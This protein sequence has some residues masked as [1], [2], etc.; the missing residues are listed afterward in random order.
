MHVSG[1][2]TLPDLKCFIFRTE[3]NMSMVKYAK[4]VQKLLL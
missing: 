1:F 4:G 3:Q 2:P